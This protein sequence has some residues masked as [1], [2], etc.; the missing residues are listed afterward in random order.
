MEGEKT[1]VSW[2]LNF[3]GCMLL[4]TAIR[5]GRQA[6]SLAVRTILLVL[7]GH[8]MESPESYSM[9]KFSS[10]HFASL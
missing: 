8:L 2:A 6:N 10:N 4:K 3:R 7:F 5:A 1:I 9:K